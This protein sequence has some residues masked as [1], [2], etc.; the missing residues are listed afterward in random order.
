MI[1]EYLSHLE[2]G[3]LGYVNQ[4]DMFECYDSLS[5]LEIMIPVL[6]I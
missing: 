5:R 3:T 2:V 4:L 1:V 6:E